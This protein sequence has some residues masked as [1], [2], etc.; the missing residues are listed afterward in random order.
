VKEPETVTAADDEM[1]VAPARVNLKTV[2]RDPVKSGKTGG[3]SFKTQ[4]RLI[5]PASD[6][7]SAAEKKSRLTA[8]DDRR[9]KKAPP[10]GGR[11]KASKP[12]PAVGLSKSSAPV[13]DLALSESDS[14]DD[15]DTY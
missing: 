2:F 4:K 8:R 10:A 13:V 5:A 11:V 3:K 14:E 7:E 6:D 15:E 1:I 9:G 12:P